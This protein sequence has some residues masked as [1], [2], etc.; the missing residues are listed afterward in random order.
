MTAP[1]WPPPSRQSPLAQ[2][3]IAWAPL[4]VVLLAYAAAGWVN[5]PLGKGD[6]VATNR[7]GFSL[8]V[9]GPAQVDRTVFGAVPTVWLQEQLVDGTLHAYDAAAAVVY[10][11]HFI[12]FP[13]ATAIV[14]FRL[15]DR[16]TSW[17]AAIV[18]FTTL[19]VTGYVVYPATPPWLASDD[20]AIGPVVRIST[21][22]W[23]Y[24]H[25][26]AVGRLIDV[27]Q[28]GSN[29]VAAMPSLHAGSALLV[30]LFLWPVAG[31]WWRAALVTY[32][33]AMALT[34]SYTGE[35]Y[36]VDVLA[37][38]LIAGVA[39]AIGVA[40]RRRARPADVAPPYVLQSRS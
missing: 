22:G 35:H 7:L 13:V 9:S 1:P 16:F 3:L 2:L 33:L 38:W 15:R 12:S 19:G 37:G 25:L 20:G 26:G 17:I 6:G 21:V 11:T 8:H 18:T 14:W 28:G 4:S 40:V 31:T 39:Y 36:V 5:A 23:D 29:P 34:L 30:V 32:V 10:S 24:L 27:G